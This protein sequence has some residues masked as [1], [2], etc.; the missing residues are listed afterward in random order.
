MVFCYLINYLDF[1]VLISIFVVKIIYVKIVRVIYRFDC[2]VIDEF[3]IIVVN[4]NL[5]VVI[6]IVWYMKEKLILSK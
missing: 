1:F 5:F 3:M 6:Y 2:Y 4:K